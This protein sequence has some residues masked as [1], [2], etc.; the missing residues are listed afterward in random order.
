MS[1]TGRAAPLLQPYLAS[2][3]CVDAAHPAIIAFAHDVTN[4]AHGPRDIAMRLYYAVRDGI[5]YD[6]YAIELT[7][8]GLCA[9]G[10]LECGRG[11]CVS[12]AVLLAAAAR[13]LGIPARL[14]YAD[15]RNH[16]STARMRESMGT[17]EF[18][19]HG[20]TALHLEGQ[21]VKATPAFN[22][23]L[24]EKFRI[25][26]LDFDGTADSLYHPYDLD[27]RRHME[28]LRYRGEYADVPIG[29][30]AADFAAHYPRM[31]EMLARGDFEREVERE[32]APSGD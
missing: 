7:E 31:M 19:W 28:Y 3:P 4:G 25:R 18:Y 16:L 21:W 24:C 22:L 6:P 29:A 23:G 20:Y 5:R 12:K 8:R 10:T 30:I 2:T 15:V 13:A 1:E 11:W 27:G 26:P 32:V 9:S 14:G 17:D